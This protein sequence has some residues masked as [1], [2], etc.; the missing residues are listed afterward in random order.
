MLTAPPSCEAGRGS[1]RGPAASGGH[2]AAGGVSEITDDLAELYAM[3]PKAT[4][5]RVRELFKLLEAKASELELPIVDVV[6]EHVVALKCPHPSV[7]QLAECVVGRKHFMQRYLALQYKLSQENKKLEDA[8]LLAQS[9]ERSAVFIQVCWRAKMKSRRREAEQRTE[10]L[11]ILIQGRWKTA[12]FLKRIKRKL[13][14]RQR[15]NDKKW[16]RLQHAFSKDW[17]RISKGRR[18]EVHLP[19][20][21][22]PEQHRFAGELNI[23]AR[24]D[25]QM[26][27]IVA[28]ALDPSV[29]VSLRDLV[30]L[31]CSCPARTR[32]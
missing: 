8:G 31:S 17:P 10:K 28:R 12:M 4:V 5:T 27:R 13:A 25:L 32:S 30:A 23:S 2:G 11:I 20:L 22:L 14:R 15:H 7:P 29:F 21:S 3:E 24:E 9:I 18:V 19:S 1:E 26:G 6:V 16:E